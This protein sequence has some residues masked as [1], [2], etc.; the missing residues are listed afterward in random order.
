VSKADA[1]RWLWAVGLVAV[2]GLLGSVLVWQ[3]LG[4]I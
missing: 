3:K 4:N 2:G 1:P